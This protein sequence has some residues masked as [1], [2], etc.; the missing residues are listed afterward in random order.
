MLTGQRRGEVAGMAWAELDLDGKLWRIP[1]E[2]TKNGKAHEIDLS[3]QA[4]AL[5]NETPN[6]GPL[7]FP[8][9]NA[10]RRKAGTA[11]RPDTMSVRG[12]SATK[13]TLDTLIEKAR[14]AR[15]VPVP[16]HSLH[17]GSTICAARRPRAWLG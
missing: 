9:R 16:R 3:P 8:A 17:G 6:V 12:F 7:L 2:R 1:R 13:R 14:R 15:T 10:P 11:P 5:I 4:I